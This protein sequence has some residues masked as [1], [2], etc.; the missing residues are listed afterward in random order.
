MFLFAQISFHLFNFLCV[1]IM[2]HHFF[3]HVF[4]IIINFIKTFEN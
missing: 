4:H 2:S 1:T 3:N